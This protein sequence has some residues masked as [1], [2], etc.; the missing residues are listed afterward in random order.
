MN[1]VVADSKVGFDVAAGFNNY[2]HTFD[3]P[4]GTV[5]RAHRIHKRRAR[6]KSSI[7][8]V[9]SLSVLWAT[10]SN[11]TSQT[12]NDVSALAAADTYIENCRKGPGAVRTQ[13]DCAGAQVH[14]KLK[15]HDFMFGTAVGGLNN[16]PPR[17]AGWCANE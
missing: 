5:I 9:A 15:E 12:T 10:V 3:L 17:R 11:T 14:V 6:G 1:L 16:T 7:E 4:A 8:L 13:R 2:E